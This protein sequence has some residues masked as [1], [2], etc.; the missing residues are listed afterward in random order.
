MYVN[1]TTIVITDL[2]LLPIYY[3]A[4][5]IKRV[6][7]WPSIFINLQN[8]FFVLLYLYFIESVQVYKTI[9]IIILEIHA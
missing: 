6:L 8:N 1:F 5:K 2:P 4:A 9:L 7:L 3:M